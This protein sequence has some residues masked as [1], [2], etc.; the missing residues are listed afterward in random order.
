MIQ[1]ATEVETEFDLNKDWDL[2]EY[3]E[4]VDDFFVESNFGTGTSTGGQTNTLGAFF[5][6]LDVFDG[7]RHYDEDNWT[8]LAVLVT[9]GDPTIAPEDALFG[10]NPCQSQYDVNGSYAD[11]G[12]FLYA[13]LVAPATTVFLDCFSASTSTIRQVGNFTSL[14]DLVGRIVGQ[15]LCPLQETLAPSIIPTEMPTLNPT[16]DPTEMPSHDPTEQPSTDPTLNPTAEPSEDPTIDPTQ[17]PTED[18]TEQPVARKWWT[19][20][21]SHPE[22]YVPRWFSGYHSHPHHGPHQHVGYHQYRSLHRDHSDSD[23]S[24]SY[25]SDSDSDS[26]SHRQRRQ[27]S[28]KKKRK[29]KRKGSSSSD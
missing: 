21:P 8:R 11:R 20:R 28:K 9:D 29:R 18:P 7:S 16:V 27:K 25:S 10:P 19:P 1:F 26:D 13:S 15:L 2:D 24:G 6:S 3:L 5:E 4:F 12:V 17:D 23:H 22:W 14:G